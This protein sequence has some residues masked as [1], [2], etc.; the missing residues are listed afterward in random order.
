MGSWGTALHQ[1]SNPTTLEGVISKLKPETKQAMYAAAQ[2]GLILRGTWDG[3]A[4]NKAG[5]EVGA[6]IRSVE[7]AA[8]VF[9]ESPSDVHR[10]IEVW[11]S[12]T[13]GNEKANRELI[14]NLE[15]VGLFSKPEDFRKIRVLR[16]RVWT[17]EETKMQEEFAALVDGLD[18]ESVNLSNEEFEVIENAF[19]AADL[20]FA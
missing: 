16:E 6:A 18:I 2:K 4:F 3:C 17:S 1:S 9:N 15:A 7:T 20:I 11:D 5:I 10:F 13:G 19:L 8:R 12:L 14:S